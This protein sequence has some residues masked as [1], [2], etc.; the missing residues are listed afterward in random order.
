MAKWA[1]SFNH[2]TSSSEV[3]TEGGSRLVLRTVA[4]MEHGL[5]FSGAALIDGR[6]TN[7]A[8]F[9]AADGSAVVWKTGLHDISAR[10]MIFDRVL[11]QTIR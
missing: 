7:C 5:C 8:A 4:D 3:G 11:T 2:I 6:P 9:V 10:L 1:A